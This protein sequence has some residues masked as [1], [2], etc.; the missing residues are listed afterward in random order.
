M[1]EPTERQASDHD[2]L[3]EPE[4]VNAASEESTDELG[5]AEPPR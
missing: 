1:S 3:V 5:D 2:D 4:G